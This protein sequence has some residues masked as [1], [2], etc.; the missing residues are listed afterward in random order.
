MNN[1]KLKNFCDVLSMLFFDHLVDIDSIQVFDAC[2]VG[3][4]ECEAEKNL[5][6]ISMITMSH[7]VLFLRPMVIELIHDDGEAEVQAGELL[8]RVGIPH[9]IVGMQTV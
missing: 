7:F 3:V 9:G 1:F 5:W 2:V 8:L 4:V 6:V